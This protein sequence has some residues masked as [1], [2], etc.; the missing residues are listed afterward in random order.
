VLKEGGEKANSFA[1]KK[2]KEMKKILGF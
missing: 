1:A 2:V